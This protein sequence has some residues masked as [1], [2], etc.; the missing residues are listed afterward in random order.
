[1]TNEIL[2]RKADGSEVVL[3]VDSMKDLTGADWFYAFLG[4]QSASSSSDVSVNSVKDDERMSKLERQIVDVRNAVNTLIIREKQKE[5]FARQE[6][7]VQTQ[8]KPS[9]EVSVSVNTTSSSAD[10]SSQEDSEKKSFLDISPNEMNKDLWDSLDEEQRA[11][12]QMK[13][14]VK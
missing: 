6:Q 3:T 9:E 11:E 13:Y 7:P 12:W 2:L 8:S 10:S 5:E 14:V 4:I 1:M